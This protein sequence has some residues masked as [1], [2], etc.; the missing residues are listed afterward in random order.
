MLKRICSFLLAMVVLL[1][2]LLQ[3][4]L[5][6]SEATTAPSV[7]TVTSL[8]EVRS[9]GVHPRIMATESDFARIRQTVQTDP[10]MKAWYAQLYA[11]GV[12][13]GYDWLY[14]SHYLYYCQKLPLYRRHQM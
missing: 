8:F 2:L 4:A 12:G 10:Y 14:Q 7:S 6:K 5:P 1:G 13:L 9:E 11:Y 3:V